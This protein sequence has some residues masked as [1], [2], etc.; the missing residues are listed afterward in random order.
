MSLVPYTENQKVRIV[1]NIVRAVKDI[2]KLNKQG[3]NFL[4]QCSGFIAH[5][6]MYGFIDFYSHV[7]LKHDIVAFANKNQYNNFRPGERA[8]EYYMSKADIYKR[9]LNA[10][11]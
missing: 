4:Y 6:D 1:N 2:N 9:I 8:Y 7:T 3:Y 11:V 5:Y 10:I